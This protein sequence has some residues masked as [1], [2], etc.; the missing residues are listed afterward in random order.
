MEA[1]G[2]LPLCSS[3][4]MK[5]KHTVQ[6]YQRQEAQSRTSLDISSDN[7]PHVDEV[8]NN[9][10]DEVNCS[11]HSEQC[12]SLTS[13]HCLFSDLDDSVTSL[14]DV[15]DEGIGRTSSLESSNTSCSIYSNVHDLDRGQTDHQEVDLG[16]EDQSNVS[17]STASDCHRSVSPLF[18][19]LSDPN[20]LHSETK[21]TG[22]NTSSGSSNTN[23]PIYSSLQDVEYRQLDH[24]KIDSGFEDHCHAFQSA[25]SDCDISIFPLFTFTDELDSLLSK[26]NQ[27]GRISSVDSSNTSCSTYSNVQDADHEQTTNQ[28]IDLGFEDHYN[29]S[30]GTANDC[31]RTIS[32][33]LPISNEQNNLHSNYPDDTRNGTVSIS[34]TPT[35]RQPSGSSSSHQTPDKDSQPTS[36]VETKP[37]TRLPRLLHWPRSSLSRLYKSL[38]PRIFRKSLVSN[39]DRVSLKK[40]VSQPERRKVHNFPENASQLSRICRNTPD[41][42]LSNSPDK[43]IFIVSSPIRNKS[44]ECDTVSKSV[45]KITWSSES[46]I[47]YVHI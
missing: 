32:P 25:T 21:S 13:S 47:R 35:H 19:F 9:V 38:S 8:V 37:Q 5:M 34:W 41:K 7:H 45:N 20:G 2:C 23:C 36:S 3:L 11:L 16:F 22:Q 30:R 6:E 27:V 29:V 15:S 40:S 31:D 12:F 10:S 18:L 1:T 24:Q 42:S 17:L 26:T 43:E 46:K 28:G 33:L 39:T 44:M 14:N 4:V